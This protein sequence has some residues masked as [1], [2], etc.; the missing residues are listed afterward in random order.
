MPD[1]SIRVI[2]RVRPQLGFEEGQPCYNCLIPRPDDRESLIRV[3]VKSNSIDQRTLGK[4]IQE[5]KNTEEMVA[6]QFSFDAVMPE[7]TSQ[8]IMYDTSQANSMIEAVLKGYNATIFA[9]GQTGSGKT[10]TMDG[11]E[12]HVRE[13]KKGKKKCDITIPEASQQGLV[14]RSIQHLFDRVRAENAKTGDPD[15]DRVYTVRC[16]FL[17]I[18]QENVYDLLAPPKKKPRKMRFTELDDR[19]TRFGLKVRWSKR[20]GFYVENLFQNECAN[21]EEC[22]AQFVRGV[23]SRTVASHAMNASS[24]RSHSIFT[25]HVSSAPKLHPE[26]T[27]TSKFHLVDLAGSE[28]VQNTGATGRMLRQ[29]IAINRSLFV[30]RKVIKSLSVINRKQKEAG[31]LGLRGRREAIKNIKKL[32]RTV[33]YRDSVLTRLL[34]NSLGGNSLTLMVACLG[35]RDA[36]RNENFSTLKYA[37]LAKSISNRAVINADPRTQLIKKLQDEVKQL[38]RQLSHERQLRVLEGG[39]TVATVPSSTTGAIEPVAAGGELVMAG[40]GGA[41]APVLAPG[42]MQLGEN[43]VDSVRMIKELVSD[44]H[45]LRNQL[46]KGGHDLQQLEADNAS[47]NKENADL[48][49]QLQFYQNLVLKK[50]GGRESKEGEAEDSSEESSSDD[51][52]LLSPTFSAEHFSFR[53]LASPKKRPVAGVA[54]PGWNGLGSSPPR[55]ANAISELSQMRS[56]MQRSS[57]GRMASPARASRRRTT[58]KR[59]GPKR[60]AWRS[61]SSSAQKRKSKSTS[62]QAWS[63]GRSRAA[64]RQIKSAHSDGPKKAPKSRQGARSA[65]GIPRRRGI[66]GSG[67][68]PKRSSKNG[69]SRFH[70]GGSASKSR[71]PKRKS[72]RGGSQSRGDEEGIPM[73]ELAKLFEEKHRLGRTV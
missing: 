33:P 25:L 13:T 47:L 28:R 49:H 63:N 29:S 32:R 70:N 12:Y 18:Y 23:G 3:L 35:P 61:T 16:S 67:S 39:G 10:F 52:G 1:S 7:G 17:Q 62:R 48:R 41:P 56:S 5:Q 42:D 43:L 54:P 73:A 31:K 24:S 46:Y 45:E 14:F 58:P 19:R 44:N 71:I 72:L 65:D 21:A 22:C 2:I 68:T 26:M 59:S 8:Q 60:E 51:D 37:A 57:S 64:G 15:V 66:P 55:P 4:S 6:H 53:H 36:V 20:E 9:Y 38:R 69:A 40:A 50:E 27:V 34:K 11:L 30:L